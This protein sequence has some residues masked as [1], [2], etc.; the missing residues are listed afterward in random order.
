MTERRV[1]L[2]DRRGGYYVRRQAE[3]Y[4]ED[5]WL[6]LRQLAVDLL[7]IALVMAFLV[8]VFIGMPLLGGMP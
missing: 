2:R 5:R 7:G 4:R 8:T 1:R 3:P 6:T